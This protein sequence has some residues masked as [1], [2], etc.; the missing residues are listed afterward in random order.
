[1]NNLLGIPWVFGSAATA[2][3][4]PSPMILECKQFEDSVAKMAAT[5]IWMGVSTM[6]SQYSFYSLGMYNG[7]QVHLT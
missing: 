3:V 5:F 6:E 1:M 4:L 7:Q 2:E